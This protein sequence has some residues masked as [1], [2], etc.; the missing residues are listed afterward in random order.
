MAQSNIAPFV[1]PKTLKNTN[2]IYYFKSPVN[3]IFN[4]SKVGTSEDG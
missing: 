3:E 4:Y 2:V 1:Y